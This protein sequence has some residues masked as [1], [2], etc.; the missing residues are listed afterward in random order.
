MRRFRFMVGSL[1]QSAI[2]RS[3]IGKE[4]KQG[5]E[6]HLQD[7]RVIH[8]VLTDKPLTLF[9]TRL[10]DSENVDRDRIALKFTD[11]NWTREDLQL[12]D[13]LNVDQAVE[14]ILSEIQPLPD[15]RVPLLEALGRVL[16]APLVAEISL[17]P[18]ANSSMDGFAVRAA[19]VKYASTE[20]PTRHCA[21]SMDIPAGSSPE[22]ISIP[23]R[24]RAS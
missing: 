7:R 2:M 19:N 14:R 10:P 6:I 9:Y 17:P 18:F 4:F 21:W 13:L 8:T 24:P 5:L 23:G 20:Q 1:D 3:N 16:A 11:Y 22:G 12:P 15:E